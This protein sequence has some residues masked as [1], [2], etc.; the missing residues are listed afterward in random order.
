LRV[1]KIA[2]CF[3]PQGFCARL[4]TENRRKTPGAFPGALP[5]DFPDI[6]ECQKAR[7]RQE[8]T[9]DDEKERLAMPDISLQHEFR[10]GQGKLLSGGPLTMHINHKMRKMTA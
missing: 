1:G 4:W 5:G 7:Q 9:D 2:K 10:V 8:N 6:C 3:V